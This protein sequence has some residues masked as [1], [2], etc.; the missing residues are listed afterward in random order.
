[1]PQG[2]PLQA[3]DRLPYLLL[4]SAADGS[5]QTLYTKSGLSPLVLLLHGVNCSSCRAYAEQ[6]VAAQKA[7][8]EWDGQ[9]VM[10]VADSLA[11]ATLWQAQLHQQG[12]ACLRVLADPEQRAA[13][14]CGM[15]PPALLI[16]DQWG[17]L[18]FVEEAGSGHQFSSPAEV[19]DWVRFIAIQCPECQAEAL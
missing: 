19:V 9:M 3:G 10:V 6:L 1:M 7:L 12:G 2:E 18:Y 4:P 5:R 14:M 11:N 17:V 13:G 15:Q 16:A 8:Q